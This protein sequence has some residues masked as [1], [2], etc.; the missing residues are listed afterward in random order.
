ME[1]GECELLRCDIL[2]QHYFEDTCSVE[3]EFEISDA[4]TAYAFADAVKLFSKQWFA[5]VNRRE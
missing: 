4:Q 1:S 3:F 5:E 2:E